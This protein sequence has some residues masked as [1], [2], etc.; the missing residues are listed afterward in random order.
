MKKL[1]ALLLLSFSLQMSV[2]GEVPNTTYMSLLEIDAFVNKV[3]KS[4][5]R[6]Y[7]VNGYEDVESQTTFMTK[8]LID[9]HV[10]KGNRYE[11]NLS[12]DE[13]SNLYRCYYKEECEL[14]LVTVSS[15]YHSGYG[16]VAHFVLL[17]T[18]KGKYEEIS[19]AIYAE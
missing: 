17:N 3:A 8:E 5:R 15:S 4:I 6:S 1:V 19:H 14:Y 16:V 7:W 18:Q 2:A 10:K 9:N 12:K 13:V 11:S